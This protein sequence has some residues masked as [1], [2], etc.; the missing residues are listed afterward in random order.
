M[1]ST[2]TEVGGEKI[3]GLNT[4]NNEINEG[5]VRFDILFYVR[6][7]DGIC[8]IIINIEVQK[9]EPTRYHILN[10]TVF[11]ASRLISSQKNREFSNSEYN[12]IKK[13]YSIWI[14][15]N[16]KKNTLEHIHLTKDS[17]IGEEHWKGRLDLLNIIMIGLSEEI[18]EQG[19]EYEL[20]RLLGT[21][22]SQHLEADEKL[23]IVESE[24]RIPMKEKLREDL[25]IMCNLGQ[26]VKEEGIA[27]GC[28]LG[29]RSGL[30]Q[31]RRE[32]MEFM[33]NSF[34]RGMR[35]KGYTV[36]QIADV[37]NVSSE[38]IIE[39]LKEIFAEQGD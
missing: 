23:R 26:G 38:E 3:T 37:L 29:H 24:Y 35:E 27:I 2:V 20:H 17:L 6:T 21:L 10:R 11:Y 4:E 15:M 22:L 30:E 36:M 18:P 13:I 34:I 14:C 31:G 9:D 12:D 7:R 16:Q 39:R 1:T 33:T 8:K 28:K 5:E 25:K 32:A 19:E